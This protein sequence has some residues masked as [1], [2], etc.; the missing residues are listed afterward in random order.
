V[1]VLEEGGPELLG[2]L[3]SVAISDYYSRT[4][5]EPITK[6]RMNPYYFRIHD[7]GDFGWYG[8]D[9]YRAW[10]IAAAMQPGIR[11]WAPTRDHLNK[12]MLRAYQTIERP[13]NFILRPSA[14]RFQDPPP[15]IE[16]MDAGTSSA[17]MADGLPSPL[18]LVDHDCPAYAGTG[19]CE[20]E[21][22][23]VCWDEPD[24]TVN[25]TPHNTTSRTNIPLLRS[26][27]G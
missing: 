14:L 3:L 15:R 1:D 27:H 23:R 18:D 17:Y 10:V 8:P 26:R 11:F 25:Y 4:H 16:G 22:C 6:L 2:E 19:H 9:Y 7:A 13:D 20:S 21:Q 12:R 24:V 5:S